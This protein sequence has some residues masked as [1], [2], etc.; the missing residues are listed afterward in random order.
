MKVLIFVAIVFGA[1]FVSSGQVV[2]PGLRDELVLMEKV[3]QDARKK[4]TNGS[5]EEQV[6]CLAEL[7]KTIDEPH[8][9]RLEEIFDQIG[10]PNSAK[11]G[12]EGMRAFM[13]VLQHAPTDALRVKSVKPITAAFKNRELSPIDYANFI[14]RLRLHQG[15]KQ[16]YGSG[17]EFK[18][19]KMI[20]SPTEDMKNLEKRRARIGLPSLAEHVKMMKEMYHMEVVIPSN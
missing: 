5:T 1:A 18:E 17:F 8:T 19:G 11:V 3:D 10:F 12:R 20:M 6:K 13:I 7:S 9:K 4:C 14:D 15:K 2:Y 16:L